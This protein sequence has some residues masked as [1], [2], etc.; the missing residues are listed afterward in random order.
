MTD[1]VLDLKYWMAHLE[2]CSEGLRPFW[3]KVF[4]DTMATAAAK[5]P[6]IFPENQSLS[7]KTSSVAKEDGG[8]TVRILIHD[9]LVPWYFDLAR[10]LRELEQVSPKRVEV[11][12]QSPGGLASWGLA[13][14]HRLR[15]FSDEGVEVVTNAVGVVASAA[16]TV[17][18][19]A[20]TRTARDSSIL[21]VHPP[22]SHV[23]AVGNRQELQR[24]VDKAM[25]ILSAIESSQLSIYEARM[26]GQNMK[27]YVESK[28]GWFSGKQAKGIGMV[29][30][31]LVDKP[32]KKD[33]SAEN[34]MAHQRAAAALAFGRGL[35][36]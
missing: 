18:L 6:D 21:M 33:D 13:L 25:N 8:D 22:W 29:T 34:S 20:D 30:K 17:Y 11:D 26:P 19:G 16:T 27:A 4:S 2:A 14:Y 10:M 35:L 32:S 1:K 24:D 23:W 3:E 28:E 7:D 36:S 31:I 15:T 12:I 5:H 9:P